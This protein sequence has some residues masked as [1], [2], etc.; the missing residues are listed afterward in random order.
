MQYSEVIFKAVFV[1][2][3]RQ[4]MG[5][6]LLDTREIGRIVA[7]NTTRIDL[8]MW[9][10]SEPYRIG[11]DF[12]EP[13]VLEPSQYFYLGSQILNFCVILIVWHCITYIV[14]MCR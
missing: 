14:L 8:P 1:D 13:E 7:S 4:A 12:V 2:K 6:G 3:M 9:L 10:R 11:A 5:V